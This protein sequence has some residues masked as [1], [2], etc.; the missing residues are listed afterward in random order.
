[1]LGPRGLMPNPKVGTVTMDVA[2]AVGE[3]KAG[4][5][6]YRVDKA[7]NITGWLNELAFVPVDYRLD[8]HFDHWLL[9]EF[10]DTSDLQWQVLANLIDE[11]LQDTSGKRS[12]FYVGDVKQ[13]IYGWRAGN[14]VSGF[15]R[16][17]WDLLE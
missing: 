9:D 2:K 12:F 11:V 6:E 7:G 5:V 1:M 15:R 14:A 13:A 4:R 16:V 3:A 8:G 10:Q 17:W